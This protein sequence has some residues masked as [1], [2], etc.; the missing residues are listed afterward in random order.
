MANSII[1]VQKAIGKL[2][3]AC[4]AH[5]QKK[6]AD[7]DVSINPANGKYVI[8]ADIHYQEFARSIPPEVDGYPVVTGFGVVNMDDFDE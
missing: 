1:G 2:E 3:E 5:F 7:F 8:L 6:I 4:N